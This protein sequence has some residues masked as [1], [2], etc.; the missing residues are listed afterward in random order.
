VAFSTDDIRALMDFE[1]RRTSVPEV[2]ALIQQGLH[3]DRAIRHHLEDWQ[4]VTVKKVL[5]RN[6]YRRPLLEKAIVLL[7]CGFSGREVA[8]MLR[9]G[10]F[11]VRKLRRR[12]LKI[13]DLKCGCG[14][15]PGHRGWCKWRFARSGKRVLLLNKMHQNQRS[16]GRISPSY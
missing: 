11:A 9:L 12:M 2:A 8:R 1:I 10:N 14:G 7:S 6:M 4:D 5:F 15:S 3:V 16:P 13:A